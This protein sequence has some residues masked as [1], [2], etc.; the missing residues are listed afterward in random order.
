MDKRYQVFVSSTFADLREE[1]ERVFQTLM[2]MDCI[3]AGM[4]IFPA[5][6]MEQWQFIQRVIDDC[7]YYVLII[8]GRYGSLTAEGMSFTER[9]FDYAVEIGLKVVAFL[10]AQPET[11]AA[12]KS[13]ME[14][15][16]RTQLLAFREKVSTGRLVKFWTTADQLP[17]LVALS[18]TKTIKLYPAVGWMRAN[19]LASDAVLTE[20]TELQKQN[21]ELMAEKA[22]RE[23]LSE[24]TPLLDLVPLTEEFEVRGEVTLERY[25]KQPWKRNVAWAEIFSSIAPFLLEHPVDLV[26]KHTLAKELAPRKGTFVQLEEQCFQSIKVQLMALDL[27]NVQYL[28]TTK[29]SMA[30]F[31]SLT[32]KG[33][34][35]MLKTRSTQSARFGAGEENTESTVIAKEPTA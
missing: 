31:W 13:E 5:A 32:K 4:E 34:S 26:V 23:R 18:L 12:S 24:A 11:I 3:P 7:D 21:R 27:V 33:R 6:D 19:A 22:A 15:A 14:P 17:G 16:L 28:K 1:R 8:G 29:E 35:L 9:E 2:E 25:G 30:L 10:H 20:L